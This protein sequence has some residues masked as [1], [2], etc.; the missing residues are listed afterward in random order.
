[1]EWLG[2][3]CD[4]FSYCPDKKVKTLY[5]SLPFDL[6]AGHKILPK[7]IPWSFPSELSKLIENEVT[8]SIAT[9]ENNSSWEGLI[10]EELCINEKENNLDGPCMGTDY[11]EFMKTI[12]SIPNRGEFES[13]YS[14]ISELHSCSGPSVT[15]SWQKDQGKFVVMSTDAMDKDPNNRHSVD[16]HDED[17][18][19]Q[20]LEGNTDSSFNFLLNQSC[21]ST[22]FGELLRSGLED[23]EVE[24]YKYLE[25]SY[26][27]CLNNTHTSLDMS[28]FPES[29][30]V[31]ETAIQKR[32]ETESTVVSSG[33]HL[34]CPVDVSLS[35]ELRPFS[36]SVFQRLAKVP[37]DPDLLVTAE[38]PKSSP[39]AIA[40]DF[41]DDSVEIAT[42]YNP[43]DECSHSDFKLESKFVD[44]SPSMEIDTVQNVWRKLRTDL[45]QH[46]SSEQI[47]AIEV[48][49]LA[50]GLSNL[51]SEAD[52]LFRNH[53][54]KQCVS[55]LIKFFLQSYCIFTPVMIIC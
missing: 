6:E 13:Q 27:A 1:M 10:K 15:S 43:M 22:S 54:Q 32:T 42:V 55:S 31:S 18:K 23:S 8:D 46:A 51:I 50:S 39:R 53:Q 21:A 47:G 35:N 17:Y 30:F 24:Q 41:C 34:A 2:E 19:R 52:L 45:K 16:V 14:A 36:F 48:V 9:V 25:T 49:K 7:M 37:Q 26:D 38:I 11:L 4:F 28:W 12:R 3:T 29:R 40:P 20:S 44:S 33:G 5:G